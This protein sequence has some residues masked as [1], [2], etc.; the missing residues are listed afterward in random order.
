MVKNVQATFTPKTFTLGVLLSTFIFTGCQQAVAPLKDGGMTSK[1]GVK[2]EAA[3]P[4]NAAVII[5]LGTTDPGQVKMMKDLNAQFPS[6]LTKEFTTGF[7]EGF[8]SGA[9]FEEIGLNFEEDILPLVGEQTE[10]VMAMAPGKKDGLNKPEIMASMTLA[11]N[12]KFD[13]LM[14]KLKDV[15]KEDYK[16]NVIYSAKSEDGSPNIFARYK[17]TVLLSDTAENLKAMLD[18]VASGESVIA[19]KPGYA[20]AMKDMKPNL[21]MVYADLSAITS[22]MAADNPEEVQGMTKSLGMFGVPT[23][24]LNVLDTEILFATAE[25]DGIRMNA[26]VYAKEG[27]DMS[28]LVTNGQKI[29]LA[30]DVPGRTPL[31]YSEGQGFKEAYQNI[32]SAMEGDEE[33]KQGMDEVRAGLK[34]VGLDFDQ[35]VMGIMDKGIAM[36]LADN[37]SVVPSFGFYVD[38]SSK[39]DSAKKI[40]G[41]LNTLLTGGIAQM[42]AQNPEA[43]AFVEKQDIEAD[44]LWKVKVNMDPLLMTAPE[45]IVKK[46]TGQ[47][48]EL[49]LGIVGNNVLALAL[50]P[51]LEKS[52][53]KGGDV[54]ANANEFK[55]ALEYIKGNDLTV[56]YFAPAAV[57]DYL[58]RIMQ[59]AK[60]T[61][62][63]IDMTDYNEVRSLVRPVKSIVLGSSGFANGV[64]RSE[65]FVHIGQ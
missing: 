4:A 27:A 60:D 13:A 10:F 54:V 17:D 34:Q 5:K 41:V 24:S 50:H 1:E 64:A 42:Q 19:S 11:N 51:D 31:L 56:T 47:K 59:L 40:A 6:D 48:V 62:A 46:L 29:Y 35:D 28:K 26:S 7:N 57:F 53:A 52:Y 49:Y 20:K 2:L 55:R 32:L 14:A 8:K 23:D 38:A 21:A 36:V 15:T 65:I 22:Q 3:I 33:M 45:D 44:K 18:R 30:K 43:S 61:G 25:K 58:D 37:G 16:G 9:K 63:N 12:A 39:P